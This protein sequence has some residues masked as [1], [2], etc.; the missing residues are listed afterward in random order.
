VM[1]RTAPKPGISWTSHI[2]E[3]FADGD[4]TLSLQQ[5]RST[6][7]ANG[8]ADAK[9]IADNANTIIGIV[10][11]LVTNQELTRNPDKT[12]KRGPK[13]PQHVGAML[14]TDFSG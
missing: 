13:H 7:V 2:R 8:V 10:G 11:R 1:I 4:T 12:I 14:P 9:T 5:L 6:L 3:V